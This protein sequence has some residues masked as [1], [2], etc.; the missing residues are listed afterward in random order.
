MERLPK[1]ALSAWEEI[2]AKC[3]EVSPIITEGSRK[4]LYQEAI[5]TLLIDFSGGRE[6]LGM[7]PF[8]HLIVPERLQQ[9]I[10]LVRVTPINPLNTEGPDT[11]SDTLNRNGQ[12]TF[13][14]AHDMFRIRNGGHFEFTFDLEQSTSE[15]LVIEMINEYL[16]Q[17]I[18]VSQ[19]DP[20]SHILPPFR[21][22]RSRLQAYIEI[23]P[24]TRKG[25]SMVEIY[26]PYLDKAVVD[27]RK[28][29]GRF[30]RT[31][32]NLGDGRVFFRGIPD[33]TYTGSVRIHKLWGND[34]D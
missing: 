8:I 18:V 1:Y 28:V 24:D 9:W 26:S 13:R 23:V 25:Q 21:L 6:R 30:K 14:T 4:F 19:S 34:E 31:R 29:K 20:K 17:G 16:S 33:G 3:N 32:A 2:I 10:E 5:F 12:I 22:H 7:F 11:Y 27:L 15:E